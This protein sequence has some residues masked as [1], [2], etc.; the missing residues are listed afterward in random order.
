[1]KE[2]IKKSLVWGL[3][4]SLTSLTV[5]LVYAT[6]VFNLPSQVWTG[7]WLS[8]TEWNK[9]VGSLDYLKWEVDNLKSKTTSE[10]WIAPTLLNWW[11]NFS[12]TSWDVAKYYKDWNNRVYI[13]W[14]VRAW[15]MWTCIFTL[16]VW[17]RP[18][19][20]QMFSVNSHNWTVYVL[21]RAD[22]RSDWCVIADS[23]ANAFFSIFWISFIAE[24]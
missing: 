16:P 2:T 9:M 6:W 5:F 8:A 7:S 20:Q 21:S 4:F 18:L 17:Y 12:P 10:A 24:Q 1:M 3:V 13:K 23:W 11:L 22:V 14:L 15:T 19:L